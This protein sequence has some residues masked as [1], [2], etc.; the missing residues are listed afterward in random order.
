MTEKNN[1]INEVDTSK[2][3]S[4]T[5]GMHRL[6][7]MVGGSILIATVMVSIALMLHYR[8]ADQLDLSRPGMN[9]VRSQVNKTEGF[10]GFTGSGEIT[11]EDMKEF[12]E[13]YDSRIKKLEALD[14]YKSDI[15]KLE[16]LSAK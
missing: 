15:L 2:P 13:L 3:Q 9:R 11:K 6:A 5:S 4:Q 7:L 10:V 1:P 8:G 14:N 16:S 12:L